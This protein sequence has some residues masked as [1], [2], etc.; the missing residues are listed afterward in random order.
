G[1]GPERWAHWSGDD[2]CSRLHPKDSS[3][4]AQWELNIL[5]CPSRVGYPES[6]GAMPAGLIEEENAVS[7]GGDLGRDL[8]EMD[9]M[10]SVLQAG[11]TRAAA[12]SRS[13]Q[14]APN[15]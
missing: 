10:A 3:F 12:M 13:G 11:S 2:G 4:S 1:S 7:L 8:V 6:C 5:P 15:R 9:C 14:T